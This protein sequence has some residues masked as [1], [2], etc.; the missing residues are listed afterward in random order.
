MARILLIDDDPSLLE[1]LSLAMEDA[2]HVVDVARDGVEGLRSLGVHRPDVVVSDVNMP[3]LD[4]FSLCR[5][6][7]EAG[8]DVPVLLLT[9]REGELDEALG[10][11]LGADDYMTKPFSTRVLLARIGVLLRRRSSRAATAG[12]PARR[13]G[14]LELDPDRMEVRYAGQPVEVTVTEYRMV[15]V[16]TGRPGVVYSRTCG[17][18]G[19]W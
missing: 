16:L 12:A 10:L 7:R 19:G 11:D 8:D 2:G 13:V 5:R 15:E 9:S 3:R 17:L 18:G 6:L 1:A 14:L 4:G